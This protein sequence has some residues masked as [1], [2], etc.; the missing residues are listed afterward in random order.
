[1]NSYLQMSFAVLSKSRVPMSAREILEAAYRLQLVPDHLFGQTQHKTLHARL[2]EDILRN[3][4]NSVFT[5]TAPGRFALRSQMPKAGQSKGE[6]VAPPRLY[7]LKHFHVLCADA[8]E[9]EAVVHGNRG[10]ILFS[11]VSRHFRKQVLLRRAEHDVGLV[12]L[13]LLVI[14]RYRDLI[15]TLAA[16]DGADMGSG[17]SLGLLGY[18]KGDDADLFSTEAFGID[19][20]ARRTVAEQSTAPRKTIDALAQRTT[21]ETLRCMPVAGPDQ[22]AGSLIMLTE[23][24]CLDPDEFIGHVPA[25]RSPRWT[26]VPAEMNDIS[27]LEPV[28][29]H[30][31]MAERREAIL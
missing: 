28:S 4:N 30:L 10:L 11:L 17:R 31:M 21:S 20:A 29:R 16:L 13:R 3:R 2:S 22:Q 7:Q 9:L 6:Y 26:R 12:R 1:M 8:L 5:R 18:V 14:I 23:F 27:G 25:N 19:A 24:E 15:L